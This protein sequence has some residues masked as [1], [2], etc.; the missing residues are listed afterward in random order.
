MCPIPGFSCRQY[1]L[2][3]KDLRVNLFDVSQHLIDIM[4]AHMAIQSPCY[5]T[6]NMW[7]S[8]FQLYAMLCS[9]NCTHSGIL[10]PRKF[11]TGF[12]QIDYSPLHRTFYLVCLIES[13]RSLSISGRMVIFNQSTSQQIH[14]RTHIVFDWTHLISRNIDELISNQNQSIYPHIKCSFTSW[15]GF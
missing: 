14:L 8:T 4:L 2:I 9:L 7:F 12:V 15:C 11:N 6:V 13:L 10:K 5:K 3:E 1:R